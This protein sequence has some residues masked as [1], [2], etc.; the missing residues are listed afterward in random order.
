MNSKCKTWFH[1]VNT[2]L[3]CHDMEQVSR[4]RH[5]N[6]GNVMRAIETKLSTHYESQW[7]IG[8]NLELIE[9]LKPLTL[10]LTMIKIYFDIK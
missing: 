5:V 3:A 8:I 10:T 2:F 1:R 6:T 7:V 9:R 4:E